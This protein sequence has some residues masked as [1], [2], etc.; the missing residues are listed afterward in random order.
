MEARIV[1]PI[2]IIVVAFAGIAGYTLPSQDLGSAVRLLRLGLVIAA[3]TAG[4]FGVGAALCLLL[5]H[6]AEIDSLG[7]NYTAPLSDGGAAP[8][9]RLLLRGPKREAET[10]V[11][12][13]GRES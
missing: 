10:R 2:A 11:A 12:D 6:L 3:V 9:S 5:L 13:R 1:S 8:L 4:L 7:L